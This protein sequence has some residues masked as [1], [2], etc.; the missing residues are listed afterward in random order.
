MRE[1][2][3][4][5]IVYLVLILILA[6][7]LYWMGRPAK[8]IR[9]A[10]GE[11][12]PGA[13]GVL[14]QLREKEGLTESRIGAV[15]P[16][17]STIKLATF[18]LR[19][20]AITVLWHHLQE[21]Q[22]RLDWNNVIVTA[23]QLVF[24]EPH[25]TKFWDFLGW[26][27]AYNASSEFDD[28]RD[29]YRWV[30]NGVEFLIEGTENNKRAPKLFK[31]T[32]MTI[33]N[34]I[35]GDASDEREQYRRLFR[36]DDAFGEFAGRHG[37]TMPLLPSDRDN[38]KVGLH[39][40]KRGEHLV[41]FEKCSIGKESE[42]MFCMHSRFNYFN[43]AKWKRREGDFSQAAFDAWHEAGEEW[44]KFGQLLLN[45]ALPKD[46]SAILK[47][48]AEVFFAKLETSDIMR[49]ERQ[50]KLDELDKLVPNFVKNL[51]IERWKQLAEK[52]GQQGSLIK[53]LED[54][55]EP[56]IKFDANDFGELKTIRKWLD[57]NEPD[58]RTKLQEDLNKRYTAEELEI[59]KIPGLLR[60]EANNAIVSKAD[61]A[62]GEIQSLAMSLIRVDPKFVAQEM[63]ERDDISLDKKNRASEIAEWF[64]QYPELVRNSD[65][66][67]EI[68][69]YEFRFREVA[70]E[71]T[72][73]VNDA[74]RLRYEGRI[75][76]YA[77]ERQKAANL[78]YDAMQK[79]EDMLNKEGFEDIPK[80]FSFVRDITEIFDPMVTILDNVNQIFRPKFALQGLIRSRI[81]TDNDT[82]GI[83]SSL[84]YAKKT[85]DKGDFP[86][87]ESFAQIISNRIAGLNESHKFMK[88]APL[89]EIRDGAILAN[90]IYIESILKQNKSVPDNL[91]LRS[92]IELMIK[93]DQDVENAIKLNQEALT[94]LADEKPAEEINAAFNNAIESWKS[95]LQKYPLIKIDPTH[96]I[97]IELIR[98]TEKY[99]ESLKKQGQTIPNDSP[100]KIFLKGT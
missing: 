30:I 41:L 67:R 77:G 99:V 57:E 45:T 91:P 6:V 66:Y 27:L 14:A 55:F 79:W 11:L 89:P 70:V 13:G 48:G 35:G 54:A 37:Y 51:C 72:V 47:D 22:K 42:F 60:D 62:I 84:E 75:A 15:D 34:K 68:L 94:K 1:T 92:F 5:K 80:N 28:Y 31:T 86:K 7:L 93:H 50:E 61:G 16:A 3:N 65:F 19:G 12:R 53:Q 46:R 73:E 63:K 71:S 24:L 36:E 23:K 83:V 29:R 69:N 49:K 32:G 88:L 100:L 56:K 95:I 44:R 78:W 39:W 96:E 81:G 43:Y 64:A 90:A 8:F 25:I 17:G 97:H 74:R 4:R 9:D 87:A 76:Y 85:F 40:L 18:G 59:K 98:L 20:V 21:Y 38:W 10:N 33:S 82:Q 52:P 2:L 58:W 26:N